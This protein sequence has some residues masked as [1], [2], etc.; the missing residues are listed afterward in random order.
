MQESCRTM[1]HSDLNA[2]F[3]I[4]TNTD[5]RFVWSAG[6]E[7]R[8]R[9]SYDCIPPSVPRFSLVALQMTPLFTCMCWLL[10]VRW[11]SEW[12]FGRGVGGGGRCSCRRFMSGVD[13]QECSAV[14]NR[15]PVSRVIVSA[16]TM[17]KNACW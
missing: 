15:N 10:F 7:E 9:A 6:D 14:R 8:V 11:L 16:K 4:G 5:Y 17:R 12:L 3:K 13:E 2:D 1:Q